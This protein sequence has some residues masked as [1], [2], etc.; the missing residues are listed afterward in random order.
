MLK[1]S[2][3]RYNKRIVALVT[4]V[5]TFCRYPLMYKHE[6]INMAENPMKMWHRAQTGF[7]RFAASA[8]GEV[9]K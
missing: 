6:K 5:T 8:T 2:Y 9:K 1:F 7:E 3:S 4:S